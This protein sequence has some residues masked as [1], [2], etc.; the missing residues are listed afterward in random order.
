MK[1]LFVLLIKN[2]KPPFLEGVITKMLFNKRNVKLVV[3]YARQFKDD[4]SGL[5]SADKMKELHIFKQTR[6]VVALFVLK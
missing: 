3:A 4:K 2:V 1:F 6:S 5:E